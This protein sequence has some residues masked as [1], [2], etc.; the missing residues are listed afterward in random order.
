MKRY[1][2][3]DLVNQ[4]KTKNKT[5]QEIKTE[6]QLLLNQYKTINETVMYKILVCKYKNTS[7]L[8]ILTTVQQV[9][10]ERRM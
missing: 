5:Q 10:Q 4:R 8:D 9:F 3:Q 6:A 7:P 2:Y 1:T